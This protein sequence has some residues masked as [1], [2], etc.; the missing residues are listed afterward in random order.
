[1]LYG[2]VVPFGLKIA[3][4]EQCRLF[5]SFDRGGEKEAPPESFQAFQVAAVRNSGPVNLDD[6]SRILI[7]RWSKCFFE[8]VDLCIDKP[9]VI[10]KPTVAIARLL[11]LGSKLYTSILVPRATGLTLDQETTGSGEE[12][13]IQATCSACSTKIVLDICRVYLKY[14]KVE[15]AKPAKLCWQSD[16]VISLRLV[17]IRF[18]YTRPF[19]KSSL[20]ETAWNRLALGFGH[21][22][23]C[24]Y[25]P[26]ISTRL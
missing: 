26:F 12:N 4:C 25:T 16:L 20:G 2:V 13:G 21:F 14:A 10:I 19:P 24:G 3:P 17:H 15:H 18:G 1:M 6:R 9:I 7:S 11:S 8:C 22:R 5:V 23:V